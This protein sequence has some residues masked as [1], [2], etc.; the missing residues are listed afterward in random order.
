MPVSPI[1]A[2]YHTV[3]PYITVRGAVK[4][5][6]FYKAAFGAEETMRFSLP[7]GTVCHAEI[8]IGD[9][10]VMLCDEMPDWGNLGPESRGGA[11]GG[12]MVYV[13]DVD[14]TFARAVAAGA[15]VFKPVE[16]QF[17]GDRSGSVTD[18]FGHKWTLGTHIEDVSHDEMQRRFQGM[19]A[20][21]G[22]AKAA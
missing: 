8:K 21:M 18:P 10:H 4:A 7:D 22:G 2:G 3:I 15:T 9:A 5:I 14:K 1:P 20:A 6:E 17:Y 19:L 11:T 13:P 16:D 12:L